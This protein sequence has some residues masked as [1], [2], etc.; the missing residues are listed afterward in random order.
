MSIRD[1]SG[2]DQALS[3]ASPLARKRRQWMIGVAAGLGLLLLVGWLVTGW[4]AGSRSFDGSRVRIA[5]VTRGDLVRDISADGRVNAANSPT[6]YAIDGGTVT[7]DVVAGDVVQKGQAPA[8]SH[9][10]E[11]TRHVVQE[12]RHPAPPEAETGGATSRA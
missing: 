3:Q 8:V 2:Q 1:T 12:Q 7:L 9:S 6:L 11:Q 5:E 10:H 4:R